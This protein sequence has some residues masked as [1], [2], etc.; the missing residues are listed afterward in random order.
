MRVEKS[1]ISQCWLEIGL[2]LKVVGFATKKDW[3]ASHRAPGCSWTD[4]SKYATGLIGF[5]KK[6][7]HLLQANSIYTYFH[8]SSLEIFHRILSISSTS[9]E[10]DHFR[11]KKKIQ[12][13]TLLLR[14][15]NFFSGSLKS[16]IKFIAD[17]CKRPIVSATP[18]RFIEFWCWW[19]IFRRRSSH[20][21]W[22]QSL[23]RKPLWSTRLYLA[24][25][26]IIYV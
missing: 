26:W 7:L 25:S 17:T 8:L 11:S 9:T 19:V 6:N 10:S 15:S 16:L 22:R 4:I 14:W 18:V 20:L 2:E 13:C 5:L 12:S 1:S 21:L 3:V 23:Q 24:A